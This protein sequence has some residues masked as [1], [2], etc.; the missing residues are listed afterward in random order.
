MNLER[1]AH[2]VDLSEDDGHIFSYDLVEVKDLPCV[3]TM[4]LNPFYSTPPSMSK[5]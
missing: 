5:A 3:N 2:M 1:E 4:V